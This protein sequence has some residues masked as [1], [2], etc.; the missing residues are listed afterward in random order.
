[1]GH[2]ELW[3]YDEIVSLRK[4]I[5]IRE[6]WHFNVLMNAEAVHKVSQLGT[7]FSYQFWIQSANARKSDCLLSPIAAALPR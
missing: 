6:A 3:M 1:M 7:F 5:S 4:P 2:S